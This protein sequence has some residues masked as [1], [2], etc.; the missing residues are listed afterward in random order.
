MSEQ[1]VSAVPSVEVV[2]LLRAGDRL[3]RAEFERRYHAMPSLKHAE[4]IN[5]VVVMPSPVRFGHHGRPHS[6][7][8]AWLVFYSMFTPG[9]ES[10]D[11]GSVR[12]SV[13][14]EPQPD[15]CLFIHP[16]CGGQTQISKDDYVELAPELVAEVSASSAAFDSG[17]K[18]DRYQLAG[19]CEYL[20]WRVNDCAL[21]WWVLRDGVYVA[22]L[23][24]SDGVIR[25]QVFLGLW[26]DPKAILQDDHARCL[27]L[28]QQGLASPEHA[29]FVRRLRETCEANQKSPG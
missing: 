12:L 22:L 5:G 21:D 15:V 11:N 26:I 28:M 6:R 25:S 27:A 23:P 4:L 24:D 8:S 19:V 16:D 7:L 1:A 9:V 10:S 13:V 3:S 17:E 14:D 18:K 2:P 20:V 29:T